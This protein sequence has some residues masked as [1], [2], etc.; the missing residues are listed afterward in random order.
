MKH[1]HAV[2]KLWT[3][4]LSPGLFLSAHY[5]CLLAALCGPSV[6]CPLSG[7]SCL[8]PLNLLPACQQAHVHLVFISIPRTL[9]GSSW[10]IGQM[11]VG[12][13]CTMGITMPLYRVETTEV[14]SIG[15]TQSR[16][17]ANSNNLRAPL[18]TSRRR[19]FAVV[20]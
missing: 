6:L 4:V 5:T 19:N 7:W 10:L 13:I 11:H 3:L 14:Y 15:V 20:K 8:W 9:S 1:S 18:T 2:C 12:L 16:S 17:P